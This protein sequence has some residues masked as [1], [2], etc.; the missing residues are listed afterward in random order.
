MNIYEIRYCKKEE[1]PLLVSFIKNHWQTDHIFVKSTEMLNFQHFDSKLLRYNFIIGFNKTSNEIDGL[2]GII[3]ISHFDSNLDVY[4]NTWGGI[5]KV[6]TD[7]VNNEITTLGSKLFSI[8]EKFNTH[9]SIGMSKVAKILHGIKKYKIGKLNHFYILNNKINKFNIAIVPSTEKPIINFSKNDF[10]LQE[11]ID[12]E[13]LKFDNIK[14]I[15]TPKKSILYL[16]NRFSKHPIYKYNF[17][18]VYNKENILQTI[19]VTRI[20][21]MYNSRVIRIV[22]V[23]GSLDIIENLYLEFQKLLQSEMC[24]YIDILNYGIDDDV[25]KKIGFNILDL[26]GD[27]IIPNYFEPFLQENIEIN[28]AHNSYD[29]YV[30]FKADADQDRPSIISNHE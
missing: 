23:Y 1:L 9:G 3:P 16:I 12:I 15:Y 30:I 29:D 11:I 5:W 26:K 7:V 18:G 22:D 27:I 25:F 21:S 24:E 6:R 4:N 28:C 13:K 2:V 14:F 19:L 20:I 8:F 10:T 17:F